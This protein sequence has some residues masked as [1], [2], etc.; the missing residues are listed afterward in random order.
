MNSYDILI[1]ANSPFTVINFRTELIEELIS[2]GHRVTVLC[3]S[4]CSLI[5]ET[6]SLASFKKMGVMHI[7]LKIERTSDSL[8]GELR[9]IMSISNT[10]RKLKPYAIL[11]FTIKA[12]LYGSIAALF[13]RKTKVFSNITGLGHALAGVTEI[14]SLKGNF[15]KSLYRLALIRNEKVFFQ[16][17]DDLQFFSENKL[18]SQSK[19]VLI[20][21][22]GVCT[23]KF[24]TG[25]KKN[26][27]P[28]IR[29]LFVGRLLRTKG[30]LEYLEAAV[31]IS[32]SRELIEF[33]VVGGADDNPAN[34]EKS[35]LECYEKVNTIKFL[36]HRN[37]MKQVYEQC[38]VFVLPSYREGTP[39]SALEAMSMSMPIITTDAPGCRE[40]VEVGA[41]GYLIPTKDVAE[42][43]N[44]M[45]NF[46]EEPTLIDKMGAESR[47]MAIRKF[48]VKLINEKII[49]TIMQ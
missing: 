6:N 44:A 42:L 12:N 18:L 22:S 16:N 32:K 45:M 17:R 20:N 11:N 4:E 13:S 43:V 34:V 15:F 19:A 7:P 23:Q 35:R 5:S 39:K 41:N 14:W 1:L 33:W 38:N 30:I 3:P 49:S 10:V 21:G 40:T 8:F 36:G 24:K 26:C 37:D 46:V 2:L 27:V 48:D 31:Q 25:R 9:C 47:Q 28:P 29:F